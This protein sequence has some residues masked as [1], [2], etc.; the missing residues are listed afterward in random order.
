MELSLFPCRP[1]ANTAWEKSLPEPGTLYVLQAAPV[2]RAG[3][4]LAAPATAAWVRDNRIW[5]RQARNTQTHAVWVGAETPDA[6]IE[7][8]DG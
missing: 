7:D 4:A 1:G 6:R 3:I 8:N 5:Q 2:V